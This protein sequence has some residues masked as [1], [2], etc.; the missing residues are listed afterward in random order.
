MKSAPPLTPGLDGCSEE[1]HETV[2]LQSATWAF[3]LGVLI[4]PTQNESCFQVVEALGGCSGIQGGGF[5]NERRNCAALEN[6]ASDFLPAL[7]SFAYR[8]YVSTSL[9]FW[10]L[11]QVTIIFTA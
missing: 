1:K 2:H 11:S 4:R 7:G 10:R 3:F 9:S 5:K 8:S 6:V